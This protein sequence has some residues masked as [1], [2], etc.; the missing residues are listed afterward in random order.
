MSQLA[1][2]LKGIYK[3]RY[4]WWNLSLADLRFK[5]RRSFLG[6]LW[7]IIQ[8][9]AM[10]ALLSIVMERFFSMPMRYLAPYIFIGMIVW[11]LLLTSVMNGCNALINA[12]SYI[13]LFKHPMAIYPL[14]SSIT[15]FINFLVAGIGVL[16]WCIVAMPQNFYGIT[17]LVCIPATVLLFL[18][19]WC[20]GIIGAFFSLRFSDLPQLVVIAMQMLWYISPV[21]FPLELFKKSRLDFLLQYNPV[22]HILE[23]FR[24]PILHGATPNVS[25]WLWSLGWVVF[26]ILCAGL[27]IV[28]LER[29]SIYYL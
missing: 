9:V 27:T 1:E 13:K 14:R 19:C 15:V 23:L 18:I 24:Q 5:Y 2:Y 16:V 6:I 4:F 21:F 12:E 17:W 20:N 25:N 26:M 29:K 28:F 22:Y 3:S 7:S 11:E 8:P 10:T